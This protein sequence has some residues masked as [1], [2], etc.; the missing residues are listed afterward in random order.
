MP[1][2][3]WVSVAPP[4]GGTTGGGGALIAAFAGAAVIDPTVKSP[5]VHNT[6]SASS[7]APR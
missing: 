6:A 3:C 5:A 2:D 1:S 7:I 4:G